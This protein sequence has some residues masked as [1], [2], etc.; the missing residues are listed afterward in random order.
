MN[1]LKYFIKLF[2][3]W[4]FYFFVNRLLFIANYLEEFSKVSSDEF[5]QIFS[6]SFGLD[7]SFIG[8]LSVVIVLFL[9]LN[10]LVLNKRINIFISG[11]IY[12]IN[13]FFIVVSAL[14]IGGEISLYAEWGTKLNFT[15]LAHFANPSEVFATG[16]IENYI[17][18]L[19]ALL[20]AVVFIK[21][22]SFYVHQ[23]FIATKYNAKQFAYKLVKLPLVLGVFLLILRGGWQAIPINLSDAYFSNTIILNDVAVNPNW[24]LVQNILKNKTNFKGNPY[25][26]YSQEKV[27]EFIKGLIDE[28]DSTNYVLST[29]TPNI[30]FILLESWSADN[31]ESLGGLKGITPKFK[32]LEKEGLLFS[33]FYSNGW[34][35]DQA[36]SS[37]FSSF[38]V[39]PHAYIINQIDKARKLPSLNNSL[40]NYHSSYFFGGQ[41][42]YGNIKGYLLSQGFDKVKDGT[43]FKHLPSGSLGVHDEYMFTQ[44]KE[45]LKEL[46]WGNP[47]NYGMY[48]LNIKK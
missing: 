34:T 20:I 43:D 42:T 39:L 48:I 41:L 14:I 2:A 16:S 27:D 18:M 5:L 26:K 46:P 25:K 1:N 40:T 44:F 23:S 4:L 15:A 11:I 8:Y 32:A 17:T 28:S 36:M 3:F 6:K 7:I 24:N 29:K 9:F 45:E 33:N 12:W 13:I 19:I 38:P 37:I 10:S 47:S 35:S 22:Y 21:I 30:V 31:I